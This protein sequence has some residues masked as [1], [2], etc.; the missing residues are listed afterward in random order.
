MPRCVLVLR[1][2]KPAA[3]M[4]SPSYEKHICAMFDSFCKTVSRNYVRNLDRV[5]N[6]RDKHF[7]DE[8]ADYILELLGHEDKYLS[9]SF[10]LYAGEY[11]KK[12]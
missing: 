1:G 5:G 4:Q 2:E 11:K 9:E 3:L 10:V 12:L 8:S 6:N 7:S